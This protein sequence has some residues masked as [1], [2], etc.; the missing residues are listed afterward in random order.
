[1]CRERQTDIL[2]TYCSTCCLTTSPSSVAKSLK[3]NKSNTYGGRDTRILKT[4]LGE[5]PPGARPRVTLTYANLSAA[6]RYI[7]REKTAAWCSSETRKNVSGEC[8]F[9]PW[10]DGI[11]CTVSCQRRNLAGFYQQ[12]LMMTT[13]ALWH[14]CIPCRQGMDHRV[15]FQPPRG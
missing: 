1:M 11:L 13:T 6:H 5:R 15:L 14:M 12:L 10:H 4:A 7:V 2:R 3:T 8:L 9:I